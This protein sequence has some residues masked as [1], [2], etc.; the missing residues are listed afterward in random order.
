MISSQKGIIYTLCAQN[1]EQAFL[2]AKGGRLPVI[3]AMMPFGCVHEY[4]VIR[5]KMLAQVHN[6]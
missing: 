6:L 5:H 3:D 1:N 2:I 4:V